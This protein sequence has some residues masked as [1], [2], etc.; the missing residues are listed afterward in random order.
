LGEQEER[1]RA[2]RMM[3]GIMVVLDPGKVLFLISYAKP[4]FVPLLM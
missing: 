2:M 3:R 1:Q 4:V